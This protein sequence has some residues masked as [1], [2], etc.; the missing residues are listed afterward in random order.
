VTILATDSVGQLVFDIGIEA[1]AV[2]DLLRELEGVHKSA[3]T[4]L[5][6]RQ[7]LGLE[8]AL[9]KTTRA[10]KGVGTELTTTQKAIK[11][12]ASNVREA[13][14][15]EKSGLSTREATV[16][17]IRTLTGEIKGQL[18]TLDKLGSEHRDLAKAMTDAGTAATRLEQAQI[19]TNRAMQDEQ[20]RDVANALADLKVRYENL[21]ISQDEFVRGARDAYTAAD[22][23]RDGVDTSSIAYKKLSDQMGIATRSAVTAEGKISRLG[24][25]QQ[26]ALGH[27]RDLRTGF[28]HL[29]GAIL[30]LLGGLGIAGLVRVAGDWA[31]EAQRAESA[32]NLFNKSVE[33]F[34]LNAGE[35]NELVGK[36]SDQF[37]VLPTTVQD[38]ATVMLRAGASLE[39]VDKALTA[40]GASAAASGFD[41]STAFENV[42]TAVATG[43]SELLESSGIITNASTAYEKYADQLGVTTDEL[44]QAQKVQALA[45]EIFEESRFE[46]E[47]LSSVMTDQ[48]RAQQNFRT[49]M[50]EARQEL[51]SQFAPALTIGADAAAALLRGFQGIPDEMQASVIGIGGVTGAVTVLGGA[52]S[53]L[54]LM[55]L[56]L[57]APPAGLIIGGVAA[58]IALGVAAYNLVQN[59]QDAGG[60]VEQFA[61]TAAAAR[62]SVGTAEDKATLLGALTAFSAHLSD[63]GKA[64]VDEYATRVRAA[65]GDF[66]DLKNEV[67]TGLDEIT[68]K[69]LE[70]K[71]K[72]LQRQINVQVRLDT[73]SQGDVDA[74][75]QELQDRINRS[76]EQQARGFMIDLSVEFDKETGRKII[77]VRDDLGRLSTVGQ[78]AAFQ[79]ADLHGQ[80]FKIGPSE[81]VKDLESQLIEVDTALGEIGQTQEANAGQPLVEPLPENTAEDV[82]TVAERTRELT[83]TY[84]NLSPALRDVVNAQLEYQNVRLAATGDNIIPEITA[85]IDLFAQW[86]NHLLELIGT[87]KQLGQ[88]VG[89]TATEITDAAEAADTAATAQAT[90]GVSADGTREALTGIRQSYIDAAEEQRLLNV[91]QLEGADTGGDYT[92]A[93]IEGSE[94]FYDA[95]K[96]SEQLRESFDLT[97][98][99]VEL[100]GEE[101]ENLATVTGEIELPMP[102]VTAEFHDYVDAFQKDLPRALEESAD[103]A[104]LF[105]E[106]FNPIEA[107]AEAVRAEIEALIERGLEPN[108]EAVQNLSEQ[109]L[110]L[111]GILEDQAKAHKNY[112]RNLDD[113]T[114]A[115]EALADASGIATEDIDDLIEGLDEAARGVG[116]LGEDAR[117]AQRD[118]EALG[119]ARDIGF[120]FQELGSVAGAALDLIPEK[121]SAARDELEAIGVNVDLLQGALGALEAVSEVA[122]DA[123]QDGALDAGEQL[124]LVGSAAGG[125]GDAIAGLD[126]I[127]ADALNAVELA[128]EGARAGFQVTGEVTGAIIGGALGL[129]V[130]LAEGFFNAGARAE[131]AAEKA[132]AAF[133]ELN[134]TLVETN[135]LLEKSEQD[136]LEGRIDLAESTGD[137]ESDAGQFQ[138]LIAQTQ[139]DLIEA[140]EDFEEDLYDIG[141]RRDELYREF[142]ATGMTEAEAAKAADEAVQP[143]IDNA[144]ESYENAVNTINNEAETDAEALGYTQEQFYNS[145]TIPSY[146]LGN[147]SENQRLALESA[148]GI[149]GD[150]SGQFVDTLNQTGTDIDVAG[151]GMGDTASLGVQG[152]ISAISGTMSSAFS[153]LLTDLDSKSGLFGGTLTRQGGALATGFASFFGT[154]RDATIIEAE[155]TRQKLTAELDRIRA[156]FQAS[157]SGGGGL[158]A[159]IG[160]G[161][162]DVG[163]VLEGFFSAQRSLVGTESFKTV[164]KIDNA[165]AD[166]REAM[167]KLINAS[168][169]AKAFGNRTLSDGGGGG[170]GGSF[171]MSGPAGLFAPLSA[172]VNERTLGGFGD[173]FGSFQTRANSIIA[174]LEGDG[175]SFGYGTS[176]SAIKPVGDTFTAR[177]AGPLGGLLASVRKGV[178]VYKEGVVSAFNSASE[179]TTKGTQALGYNFRKG[180]IDENKRNKA[181]IKDQKKTTQELRNEF[182]TS[183]DLLGGKKLLKG[184]GGPRSGLYD[185]AL[186]IG[187]QVE[188]GFK[189]GLTGGLQGFIFG[190][191]GLQESLQR[192]T[193]DTAI[194]GLITSVMQSGLLEKLFGG[195]YTNLAAELAEGDFEGA[196]DAMQQVMA[197]IP[198]VAGQLEQLFAPLKDIANSLGYGTQ[199]PEPTNLAQGIRLEAR[200]LG[201][202]TPD[203]AIR[204]SQAADLMSRAADI[205]F[206][207]AQKMEAAVNRLGG[208]KLEAKKPRKLLKF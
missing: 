114:E 41:I 55:L 148:V 168:S 25:S 90:W 13:L 131:E 47:D 108:D 196:M 1:T 207:A 123:L 138:L 137:F 35:A 92:D 188:S 177:N 151:R 180:I 198:G 19:K 130:G 167:Q 117:Q 122:F 59:F 161:Q 68:R 163:S 193:F 9:D 191:G 43:R 80:L 157:V 206:R 149:F 72:E 87:Q 34:G 60:P 33:R 4:A 58:L 98:G 56:P 54:R 105:G 174:D 204:F 119:V 37:G 172:V 175:S 61:S 74:R 46:I 17:T 5:D 179:T 29:Q 104:A 20:V 185:I 118:L 78:E 208:S 88:E 73:P 66:S 143:L 67:I 11:T 30:P 16:K 140:N 132:D 95:Y 127:A 38:A 75:V 21:D 82:A 77:A 164:T 109:Y 69:E 83:T 171:G 155:L 62:D 156:E 181:L 205:Q 76:S 15:L 189:S 81:Q 194:N 63:D 165:T 115:Q 145:L 124:A 106:E 129:V 178:E 48:V 8:D 200:S 173:E 12:Y 26:V 136:V 111:Q 103:M 170:G 27:T 142:L 135:E 113:V 160:R 70:L 187:Q 125:A 24:L 116:E 201:S 7:A 40:A 126:P 97:A 65:K 57:F 14:A 44:T 42:G 85:S 79:I 184:I 107:Q 162:T 133:K 39:D 110:T 86:R 32:S 134:D 101:F 197:K 23:L 159:T 176:F 150:Y 141:V 6:G 153:T 186:E 89:V 144:A 91:A 120:M 31:G 139:A 10:A 183:F 202:A 84:E 158:T 53:G 71:R 146:I 182:L 192:M 190:T 18:S 22:R 154:Q 52:L 28:S 166:I 96:N 50:A 99:G 169:G 49:A 112:T 195:V 94:A 51:G 2:K 36:L 93:I 64:A 128:M 3:Q 102:E 121:G 100:L 152:G 45:N 147:L 199:A 203:W